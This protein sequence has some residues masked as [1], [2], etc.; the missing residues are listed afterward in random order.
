MLLSSPPRRERRLR[1]VLL[2]LQRGDADLVC[3]GRGARE[4]ALGLQ[5]RACGEA[6]EAHLKWS[7][8][9]VQSDRKMTRENNQQTLALHTINN[10]PIQAFKKTHSA[11]RNNRSSIQDDNSNNINNHDDNDDDDDND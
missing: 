10:E 9:S 8:Y 11:A 2:R 4:E 3:N 6:L 7:S 1:E 5:R